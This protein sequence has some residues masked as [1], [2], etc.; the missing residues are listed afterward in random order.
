MPLQI[1]SN[2]FVCLSETSESTEKKQARITDFYS[3]I[4]TD[5]FMRFH[6]GKRSEVTSS[7]ASEDGST[8]WEKSPSTSKAIRL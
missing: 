5:T 3:V 4:I 7:Q 6:F 8:H 1:E 2:S